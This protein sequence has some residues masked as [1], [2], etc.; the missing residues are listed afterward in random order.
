MVGRIRIARDYAFGGANTQL[1]PDQLTGALVEL[2]HR[3]RLPVARL[4]CG[5]R[6][7]RPD[8]VTVAAR[9]WREVTVN[10]QPQ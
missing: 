9:V 10:D 7:W 3:E 8:L 6:H 2:I 4:N 5:W 1:I